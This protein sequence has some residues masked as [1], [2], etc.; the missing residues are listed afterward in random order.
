MI[1]SLPVALIAAR[2][3]G[4]DIRCLGCLRLDAIAL[5]FAVQG[6]AKLGQ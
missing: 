6:D 4:G 2:R 1:G 3:W 5:S